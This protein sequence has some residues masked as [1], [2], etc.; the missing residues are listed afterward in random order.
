MLVRDAQAH[1]LPA[2]VEIYN[3]TIP[4]RR[5]TADLEPV[6]VEQRRAWFAEHDPARRPLWVAESGGEVVAWLSLHDYHQ[7]AG[8]RSTAEVAVYVRE[9]SRG[10]GIGSELLAR[11]LAEAPRLEITNLIGIIFAHNEQSVALFERAGFE[12]WGMLPGVAV[13]D[14]IERDVVLLGRRVRPSDGSG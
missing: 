9:D 14:G 1:D 11:A 10:S 13:L 7:R 6:T 5:S 4:T 12:R 2:I 8:Y 3:A